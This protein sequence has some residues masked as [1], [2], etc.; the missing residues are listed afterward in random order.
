MEHKE[1]LED[2]FIKA[3]SNT[4]KETENPQSPADIQYAQSELEESDKSNLIKVLQEQRVEKEG[5]HGSECIIHI[6]DFGGDLEFYN[7]HQIFLRPKCVYALIVSLSR[8]LHEEISAHQMP[9]H[10]TSVKMKYHQQIE[11]WLNM[12]AS[13]AIKQNDR[14]KGNVFIVGTKKDLLPGD[15]VQQ[16]EEAE[17]YYEELLDLLENKEHINLIQDFVAVDSKGGDPVNY[18]KLREILMEGIEEHCIWNETRPIRWLRLEK[19]LHEL[20]DECNPDKLEGNVVSYEKVKELGKDYNIDTEEGLK[21][22]L[23]FHHLTADITFCN[24]GQLG[25]YVVANPQWLIN[26]FRSLITLDQFLPKQPKYRNKK[27][28]LTNEGLVDRSGGL[29]KQVW[30]RFLK[31]SGNQE[32]LTDYLLTLMTEFDLAVKYNENTYMI[33]CMLPVA[34]NR[35]RTYVEN[36][37]SLYYK[38][39]ASK[40]SHSKCHAGI[41]SDDNFLPQGLFQKLVSR[42]SKLSQEE[43]G[44]RWVDGSKQFQN[45]VTFKEGDNKI[46]LETEN[47]WIRLEVVPCAHGPVRH[48][49]YQRK[50]SEQLDTL[51]ETYHRNM[52]YE[53]AVNPCEAKIRPGTGESCVV[54][55]GLSRIDRQNYGTAVIVECGSHGNMLETEKFIF[56]FSEY[57]LFIIIE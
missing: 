30:E 42:C 3:V 33:P 22:F 7:L 9:Y 21:T 56:W 28:K 5:A 51:L 13:H 41:A 2:G 19:K 31:N 39:H 46:Y 6:W 49:E 11:F 50:V 15:E 14:D 29:L 34:E 10:G 8:D 48:I 40:R 47:T 23:E 20:K 26:M 45:A 53:F 32:E 16:Q 38:F 52:W 12:I 27:R 17:K 43:S 55:S 1:L 25:K 36:S 37:L 18:E 35:D 24:S 4:L 54:G 57:I 44:W